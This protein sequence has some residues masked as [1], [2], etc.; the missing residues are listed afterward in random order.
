[1]GGTLSLLRASS[2]ANSTR[3]TV[4]CRLTL[5]QYLP[6][7]GEPH[8]CAAIWH[9]GGRV[10]LASP[11][12]RT[13]HGVRDPQ[14]HAHQFPDGLASID[15]LLRHHDLARCRVLRRRPDRFKH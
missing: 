8:F 7:S 2:A 5:V 6:C 9:D 10:H 11:L 3:P 14:S 15:V 4:G 1:M 13:R 12:P